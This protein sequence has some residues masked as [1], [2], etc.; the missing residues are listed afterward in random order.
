MKKENITVLRKILYAV[1]AGG[2][3]YGN[4]NYAPL[5]ASEQIQIMR[6]LLRLARASGMPKKPVHFCLVFR[7]STQKSLRSWIR[8]VLQLT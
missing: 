1:E 5:L 3:V 8:P 6:R 4:Q 7:R 2:Q